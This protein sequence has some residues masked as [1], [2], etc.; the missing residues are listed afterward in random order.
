MFIFNYQLLSL[1][2]SAFAYLLISAPSYLVLRRLT[3]NKKMIFF[4]LRTLMITKLLFIGIDLFDPHH[5]IVRVT[6]QTSYLFDR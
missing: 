6:G 5:I 2:S 3:P 4:T 1:F